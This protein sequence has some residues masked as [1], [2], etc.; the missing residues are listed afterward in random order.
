MVCSAAQPHSADKHVVLCCKCCWFVCCT[1]VAV[2][3]GSVLMQLPATELRL[4]PNVG[5]PGRFR[6]LPEPCK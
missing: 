2:T 3:G 1:L 6:F 5:I 4:Q